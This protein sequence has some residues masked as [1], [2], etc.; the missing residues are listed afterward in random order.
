[1][2]KGQP[3]DVQGFS[4]FFFLEDKTSAPDVFLGA[5]RL[6]LARSVSMVTRYDV[7]SSNKILIK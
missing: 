6:S 2:R 1:M 5:V 4:E 7:I 3:S